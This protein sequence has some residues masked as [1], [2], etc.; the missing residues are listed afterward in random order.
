MELCFANVNNILSK[1]Q[2]GKKCK[3]QKANC[4]DMTLEMI[5]FGFIV[6]AYN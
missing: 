1:Y 5:F 6:F 2:E 3:Q 4:Q